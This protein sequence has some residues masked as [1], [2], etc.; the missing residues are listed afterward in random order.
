MPDMPY[1]V[2]M[3]H[4]NRLIKEID[5]KLNSTS[6][7]CDKYIRMSFMHAVYYKLFGNKTHLR[8]RDFSSEYFK[9]GWD[10]SYE[11][12]VGR[13]RTLHSGS[14]VIFPIVMQL[15]YSSSRDDRFCRDAHTGTYSK[16]TVIYSL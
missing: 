4:V 13:N 11:R 3:D 16:K 8:A 6:E 12:T 9:G 7:C 15:Y 14:K 2:I 10:Q 1:A 5:R